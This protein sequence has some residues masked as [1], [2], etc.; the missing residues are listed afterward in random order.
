MPRSNFK[1]V[2]ALMLALLMAGHQ[3]HAVLTSRDRQHL[4]ASDCGSCHLAGKN[5][6]P[7]QAGLLLASQEALCAKCHPNT[8][9]VSHPSGFA[10][11][12][13]PPES[14]PLDWKGDLTCSTCHEIHGD[15][16]GLR[17]DAKVGKEFC[18]NCHAASFFQKMRDGGVSTM[19]GHL[20]GGSDVHAPTLDA[21]S[22]QC[23]E[24][25]ERN[26]D[27]RLAASISR[28]GILRH[29]SNAVNHPIGADYQKAVAFGG[30]RARALVERKILLPNGLVSCVSCHLG[31]S[32][33]HGKLVQVTA[34]SAL[35]F[36]CHDL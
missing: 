15:K 6:S 16:P 9:K 18:L 12:A 24:C 5:V 35:C 30:Y 10:P 4:A 23:L 1:F 22:R 3:L 11:K 27:P 2:A 17:R 13:K 8:L 34:R 33:D 36:E 31:Y 20:S 32:K 7:Q 19:V 14:Y 25:H 21:Y 28:N 26:G 29:A